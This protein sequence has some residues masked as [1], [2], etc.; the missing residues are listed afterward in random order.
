[1]TAPFSLPHSYDH[2]DGQLA[3]PWL[4]PLL[5]TTFFAACPAHAHGVSGKS[6]CNL[7]CLDCMGEGLCSL[8][9]TDHRDHHVVQV[10]CVPSMKTAPI[11]SCL[12]LDFSLLCSPA[13][14]VRTV[15]WQR[16]LITF[17]LFLEVIVYSHIHR[18][19]V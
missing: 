18:F 6:E 15:E 13:K 16:S 9:L 7:W 5:H 11:F 14:V 12:S 4:V 10:R 19:C 1:M 8:C 3:P 2:G 17:T